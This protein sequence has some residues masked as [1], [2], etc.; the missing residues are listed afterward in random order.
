MTEEA[1]AL[2]APDTISLSLVDNTVLS[3][4]I[5][6]PSVSK[7]SGLSLA[8]NV[9]LITPVSKCT[10]TPRFRSPFVYPL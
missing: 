2:L 7:S 6:R 5:A 9:G 4:T 8:F 1:N 10:L 3:D